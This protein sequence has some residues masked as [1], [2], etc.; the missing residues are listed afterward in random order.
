MAEGYIHE[1]ATDEIGTAALLLG[2]GRTKKSDTIDPG[3][4]IWM[5][6]RRGDRVMQGEEIAVFHVNDTRNLEQAKLR[7][8]NS[9]VL[10]P[11]APKKNPLIYNTIS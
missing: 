10:G 2:A 1:V 8:Q 6:K 5:K 9:L 11:E 4:G 7:F 3:V